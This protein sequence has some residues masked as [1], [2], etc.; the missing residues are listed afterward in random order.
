MNQTNETVEKLHDTFAEYLKNHKLRNTTERNAIFSKIC[1]MKHLFTLDTIGQ[2]LEEEN[3]HVSRA[4]VYN[5]M[6]LLLDAKIVIRHQFAYTQ[7]FYEL[8]RLSD[9]HHYVVCKNCGNVQRIKNEKLNNT[10][11][12]CKIP[13]FTI[14]YYSLYFYGLCSKCKYKMVREEIKKREKDRNL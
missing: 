1:N 5:T 13:K 3:F 8:K 2:Q 7:V 9:D 10:L 4:S 11:L 6:E 12:G 14:E